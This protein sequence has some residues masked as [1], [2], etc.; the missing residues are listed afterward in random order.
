MGCFCPCCCA[1]PQGQLCKLHS[2]AW[3]LPAAPV[4]AQGTARVGEV[5]GSGAN[6][7]QAQVSWLSSTV[8]LCASSVSSSPSSAEECRCC[9]SGKESVRGKV[10]CFGQ[11]GKRLA[12]TGGGWEGCAV[13]AHGRE[14]A[15]GLGHMLAEGETTAAA[16]HSWQEQINGGLVPGVEQ[17]DHC[18]QVTA[19]GGMRSQKSLTAPW[20]MAGVEKMHVNMCTFRNVFVLLYW[21]VSM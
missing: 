8:Y 9:C 16:A 13:C 15:K 11:G 17:W 21:L 18:D 19:A 12:V 1:F 3:E 4:P 14:A 2:T 7:E 5:L 10:R 20:D 6:R